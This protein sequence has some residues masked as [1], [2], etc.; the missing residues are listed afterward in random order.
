M[1][2]YRPAF[3]GAGK[4]YRYLNIPLPYSACL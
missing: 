2:V 1:Y 4:R 3:E